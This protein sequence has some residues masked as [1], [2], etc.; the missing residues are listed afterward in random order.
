MTCFGS[1]PEPKRK[2]MLSAHLKALLCS[3]EERKIKRPGAS[4]TVGRG[5]L[6]LE[7]Q[8]VI[9]PLFVEEE[10]KEI[11]EAAVL[12]TNFIEQ[13]AR[14]ATQTAEREKAAALGAEAENIQPTSWRTEKINEARAAKAAISAISSTITSNYIDSYRNLPSVMLVSFCVTLTMVLVVNIG[15]YI[16]LAPAEKAMLKHVDMIDPAKGE[17]TRSRLQPGATLEPG[18]CKY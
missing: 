15:L 16:A 4:K 10:Q 9:R 1:N 8:R 14:V 17:F 5:E 3:S 2:Q 6:F 7:V 18:L 12:L 11:I 13:R